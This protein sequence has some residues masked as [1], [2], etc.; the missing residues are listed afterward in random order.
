MIYGYK[1]LKIKVYEQKCA[2]KYSAI[3]NT[4]TF[5]VDGNTAEETVVMIMFT[6]SAVGKK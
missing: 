5:M 1:S 6:D 4:A 3:H 2:K